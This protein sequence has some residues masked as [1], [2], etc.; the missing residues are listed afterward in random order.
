[1]LSANEKQ[2]RFAVG[3]ELLKKNSLSGLILAGNG[4]V[5]TNA[6]G[7]YRYFT[8]NRVY[9]YL[10]A[11]LFFP[12]KEPV[13]IVR[14]DVEKQE[15]ASSFIGDCR[16]FPDYPAG[17][18][19]ILEENG[20]RS[21]KIGTCL[22]ILPA[23]WAQVI[24]DRFPEIE[25][26]DIADDLFGARNIHSS[27]E[28]ALYRHCA[29]LADAGYE[30]VLKNVHA[31]MTEQ[32]LVAEIEHPILLGGG[33]HNFTLVSAGRFSLKDNQLPCIRAAT[34]FN[35]TINDG[36]CISMEITPRYHGYWTQLVRTVCVGEPNEDVKTMHKIV[37]GAIEDVL[38]ELRPGNP[39]S[40]IAKRLRRYIESRG[41]IFALPCGHICGLDLNEERLDEANERPLVPGMAVIIHPSVI[42]PDIP[43]G[44]FWG[45]TYLITESGYESLMKTDNEL[46]SVPGK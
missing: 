4:G 7:C 27:E 31:G 44:I 18:C 35:R 1:M 23:S 16:V 36:D 41:Y 25:L 5:G 11:A 20:V 15:A 22:D 19:A 45:Q 39:I 40:S 21:G 17:I 12:G 46:H 32:E 34:M 13:G 6:Y 14:S 37:S 8:D 38:V 33:E 43:T 24:L 10:Q 42:T 29:G 2:R 30:S 28:I 26:T 3:Q 9:R